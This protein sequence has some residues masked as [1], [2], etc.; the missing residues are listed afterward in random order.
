MANWL[1]RNDRARF[2]GCAVS[3]RPTSRV[4]S[5]G[6]PSKGRDARWKAQPELPISLSAANNPQ[7]L[8]IQ[9]ASFG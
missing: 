2:N 6:H 5:V 3:Q 9:G 1:Q 7:L 8:L 4:L